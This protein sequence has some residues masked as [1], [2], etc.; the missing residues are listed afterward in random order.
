MA[1]IRT[2]SQLPYPF[3]PHIQATG[4]TAPKLRH[5]PLMGKEVPE[6]H[7]KKK[8]HYKEFNNLYYTC[9][10]VQETEWTGHATH[11]G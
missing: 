8:V 7:I 10:I 6:E 1:C 3:I 9:T 2:T 4:I 11:M 5:K